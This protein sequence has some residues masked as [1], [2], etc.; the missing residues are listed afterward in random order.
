VKEAYVWM[1]TVG[2]VL[3]LAGLSY[4]LLLELRDRINDWLYGAND[5]S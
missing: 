5:V 2:L 1:G 4:P 3:C